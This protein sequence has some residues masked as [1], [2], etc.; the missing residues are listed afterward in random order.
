MSDDFTG[1]RD[2]EGLPPGG[3]VNLDRNS[4]VDRAWARQQGLGW[5]LAIRMPGL[6]ST[7][8]LWRCSDCREYGAYDGI[9]A[10]QLLI[11][12]VKE[13][14]CSACSGCNCEDC[15]AHRAARRAMT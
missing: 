15:Q 11:W 9:G 5:A 4:F 6:T 10:D 13:Q 2:C 8:S 3:I 14:R 12:S 1:H 7:F